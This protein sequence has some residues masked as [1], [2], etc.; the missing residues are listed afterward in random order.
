MDEIE[1]ENNKE[2]E[3]ENEESKSKT[4]SEG[5]IFFSLTIFRRKFWRWWKFCERNYTF[6]YTI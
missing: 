6:G 2:S 5:M 4:S 3:E 1:S